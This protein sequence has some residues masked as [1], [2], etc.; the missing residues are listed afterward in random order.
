MEELKNDKKERSALKDEIKL[1][2]E[3]VFITIMEIMLGKPA[4]LWTEDEKDTLNEHRQFKEKPLFAKHENGK[5]I[6]E[7]TDS[8]KILEDY[9]L[10]KKNFAGKNINKIIKNNKDNDEFEESKFRKEYN[11]NNDKERDCVSELRDI[12]NV[13]YGHATIIP[14]MG[15]I[16]NWCTVLQKYI[17]LFKGNKMDILSKY[18]D[19]YGKDEDRQKLDE[20][21]TKVTNLRYKCF[22]SDEK[23]AVFQFGQDKYS[24]ISEDK[25]DFELLMKDMAAN[26][27]RGKDY[28]R[29][30][31]VVDSFRKFLEANFDNYDKIVEF[32]NI[33]SAFC[34]TE[35]G[36]TEE[37]VLYMSLLYSIYPNMGG[38][39]WKGINYN[40]TYFASRVL[41]TL[42]RHNNS[43]SFEEKKETLKYRIDHFSEWGDE[44]KNRKGLG[45]DIKLFCENK[46]LSKYFL[47]KDDQEGAKLAKEFENAINKT[48]DEDYLNEKYDAIILSILKLTKYMRGNVTYVLP[49]PFPNE[50]DSKKVFYEPSQFIEYFSDFISKADSIEEVAALY[51]LV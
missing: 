44:E 16:Y 38:I 32:E 33:L 8:T 47:G 13:F 50:N 30:N 37:S 51:P 15:Q 24:I 35:R 4:E 12:R 31:S 5:I 28:L 18:D 29:V 49:F 2:T 20:Y 14:D 34:K 45:L 46:I 3:E 48:K 1:I 6:I 36:S 19:L 42:T 43:F 7:Y 41:Q 10:S 11:D 26:W 39:Y 25:N 23:K 40:E 17:Q 9:F 27:K 21:E 22:A